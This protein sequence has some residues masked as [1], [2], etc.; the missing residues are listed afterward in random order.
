MNPNLGGMRAAAGHVCPIDVYADLR[1]R[2]KRLCRRTRTEH[3]EDDVAQAGALGLIEARIRFD[4]ERG[5]PFGAYANRRVT[6]AML[7]EIRAHLPLSRRTWE[8]SERQPVIEGT[9]DVEVPDTGPAPEERVSRANDLWALR[10]ALQRL[11]ESEHAVIV[12]VYDFDESGASGAA[13]ARSLGCSR[14][15]VSRIHRGVLDELR[16]ALSREAAYG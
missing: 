12:A 15:H 5:V 6:G 3:I 11:S 10:A 7:D 13:H 16:H 8:R 1:R 14:S 4:P 9:L 2:A